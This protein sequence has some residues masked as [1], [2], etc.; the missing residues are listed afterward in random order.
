MTFPN[1]CL[2]KDFVMQLNVSG[3]SFV[4]FVVV[5]VFPRLKAHTLA[6]AS[7]KTFMTV[8]LISIDRIHTGSSFQAWLTVTVIYH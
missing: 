4:A 1:H 7:L 8:A 3:F 5:V 6:I 2:F